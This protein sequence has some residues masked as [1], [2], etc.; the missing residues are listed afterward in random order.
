MT[1]RN[2]DLDAIEK[3]FCNY[4][5]HC[6]AGLPAACNC[7]RFDHRPAILALIREV[8]RLRAEQAA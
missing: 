7:S 4:C 8:R 1:G 6:D 2:L 5:G 3:Q